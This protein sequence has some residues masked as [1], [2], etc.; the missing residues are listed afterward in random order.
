MCSGRYWWLEGICTTFEAIEKAGEAVTG[1]AEWASRGSVTVIGNSP[2]ARGAAIF[3]SQKE[4][5]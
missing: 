4:Q 2:M 1:S 5:P 3:F